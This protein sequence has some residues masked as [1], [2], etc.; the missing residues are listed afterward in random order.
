MKIKPEIEFNNI[1]KEIHSLLKPLNFKKKGNNFYKDYTELGHLINIQK[2]RW[3]SKE[4]IQFTINI[5]IFEP[6]VWLVKN[7]K[8]ELPKFPK[9]IDCLYRERIGFL[10]SNFDLWY[11]IDNRNK[12]TEILN[13]IKEY[14]LPFLKNITEKNKLVKLIE[15][16]KF[17]N[18]L[19]KLIF[20]SENNEID[21]AKKEYKNLLENKRIE[22]FIQR[23]K[24]LGKKYNLDN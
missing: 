16:E 4:E 24:E 2:S 14:V 8:M 5:G 19:D 9:E 6:K 21:K 18:G 11:K 20:F 22:S 15:S 10:K 13:D 3:N 17:K 23:V 12:E 7:D 1:V